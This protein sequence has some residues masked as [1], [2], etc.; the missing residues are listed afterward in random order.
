MMTALQNQSFY[1]GVID[2]RIPKEEIPNT[3]VMI[4]DVMNPLEKVLGDTYEQMIREPHGC[5]EQVNRHENSISE[6]E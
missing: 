1:E 2:V 6:N 4:V 3:L 5:F